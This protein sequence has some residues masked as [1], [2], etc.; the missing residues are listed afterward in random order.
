MRWKLNDVWQLQLKQLLLQRVP[1]QERVLHAGVAELVD[2]LD[3]GSSILRCVGSSP[4]AR[5]NK[6]GRK[7][8]FVR[9]GVRNRVLG[10]C[11]R[12]CLFNTN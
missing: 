12:V 4:I 8:T 3:L 11:I 10:Q 7:A 5:T 6:G 1:N 9:T 2:A